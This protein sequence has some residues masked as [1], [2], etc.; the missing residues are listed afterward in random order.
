MANSM[1]TNWTVLH[2]KSLG[3]QNGRDIRL[4]YDLGGQHWLGFRQENT[5]EA[6][7]TWL[8]VP[9][10]PDRLRRVVTGEMPP[11]HVAGN[12]D[13]LLVSQEESRWTKKYRLVA[14][15]LTDEA[16]NYPDIPF[17]ETLQ[18]NLAFDEAE[19]NTW[20][21][22]TSALPDPFWAK[23]REETPAPETP[24]PGGAKPG[25]TE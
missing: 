23:A 7:E 22:E 19:F 20:M 14:H 16:G 2:R 8:N 15:H 9:V 18:H 10:S 13:Y 24:E 4:T 21:E 17:R 1:E 25:G 11:G 12:A 5:E 6:G 3:A